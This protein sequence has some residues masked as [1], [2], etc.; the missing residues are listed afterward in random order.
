[1]KNATI[2][3]ARPQF[4]KA[5][6]VNRAIAEHN[7]LIPH[8]SPLTEVIIHT[9]QHYDL[10]MSDAFLRDLNL[11]APHI[12][13]NVG[14]GTQAEQTG[15][16]MIGYEKVLVENKLDLVVVVGDVNST[17]ACTL[18]AVKLGVKVAPGII[19]TDPRLDI[20]PL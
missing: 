2:I 18:A 10:N 1:M 19:L 13:L 20:K 12:H 11:P 9:G 5:A 16:V 4:I 14:S 8:S 15:G 6:P 3:G 17:V 7:R